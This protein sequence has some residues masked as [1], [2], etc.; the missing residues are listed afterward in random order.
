MRFGLQ[1]RHQR[2]TGTS[3]VKGKKAGRN[4]PLTDEA[5]L[6][7]YGNPVGEA[8]NQSALAIAIKVDNICLTALSGMKSNMTIDVSAKHTIDSHVIADG[9]VKS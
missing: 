3:K 4:V 8:T 1:N 5:V 6:S 7:G 2:T 9:L